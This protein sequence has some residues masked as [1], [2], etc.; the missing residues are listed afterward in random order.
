MQQGRSAQDVSVWPTTG[1]LRGHA[2]QE[3]VVR[4]CQPSLCRGEDARRQLCV[5]LVARVLQQA[6][7]AVADGMIVVEI[8]RAQHEPAE[9]RRARALWIGRGGRRQE[10]LQ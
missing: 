4:L 6:Q 8:G 2:Q 9:E 3:R 10:W 7:D 5:A 1:A